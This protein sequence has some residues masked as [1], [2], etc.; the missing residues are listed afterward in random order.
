MHGEFGVD[1]AI[2]KL[3]MKKQKRII[4]WIVINKIF[5]NVRAVPEVC[6]AAL[7]RQ[8]LHPLAQMTTVFSQFE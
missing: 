3:E 5:V 4:L 2:E 6:K 8:K 1:S 7:Q